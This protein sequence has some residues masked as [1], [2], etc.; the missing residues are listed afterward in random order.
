[1]G[2]CLVYHWVSVKGIWFKIN[3]IRQQDHSKMI[4]YTYCNL[5]DVG[6][7]VGA[8]VGEAVGARIHANPSI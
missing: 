1:M 6:L 2:E 5:T 7:G 8:G 3:Y 4:W